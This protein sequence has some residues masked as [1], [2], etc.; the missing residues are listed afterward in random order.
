MTLPCRSFCRFQFASM[1]LYGDA[2]Q[3][4]VDD[5]LKSAGHEDPPLSLPHTFRGN[6]TQDDAFQTIIQWLYHKIDESRGV[7]VH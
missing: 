4:I 7:D 3:R 2:T 6:L 1:P 5:N